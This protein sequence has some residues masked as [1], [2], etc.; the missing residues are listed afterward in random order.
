MDIYN[1]PITFVKRKA[2][3]PAD[4]RPIWR[5]SIIALLLNLFGRSGKA[6]EQKVHFLVSVLRDKEKWEILKNVIHKDEL[7]LNLIIRFDPSV[8][9]ALLFSHAEGL[10]ERLKGGSIKLTDKGLTFSKNI[11][12]DTNLFED[13]K[14]FLKNFKKSDFTENRINSIINLNNL[15]GQS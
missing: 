10:T 9:R 7:P 13:E 6:S 14:E 12:K 11:L 1:T 2:P 15:S 8:N 3:L 5:V 4:M